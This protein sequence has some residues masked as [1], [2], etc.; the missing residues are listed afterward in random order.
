MQYRWD[1]DSDSTWDTGWSAESLAYN[2][3]PDDWNGL[4]TVVVTDGTDPTADTVEVEV[5]N[6]PPVVTVYTSDQQADTDQAVSFSGSFTDYGVLD[7]HV[8][9]WDFGDGASSTG[10]LSAIHSYSSSGT[11]T[12]SLTVTDDDGGTDTETVNIVVT[13]GGQAG[14]GGGIVIID[15]EEEEEED[16]ET[17]LPTGPILGNLETTKDRVLLDETFTISVVVTN[18]SNSTATYVIE[19]EL[20]GTV[21][22]TKE[23]TLGGSKSQT[24]SFQVTAETVGT[25]FVKI[26]ELTL[27]VEVLAPEEEVLPAD[28]AISNLSVTPAEI[29][30]GETVVISAVITN[31]GGTGIICK[32]RRVTISNNR[33]I[34]NGNN[35]LHI[36]DSTGDLE[37][38]K[39][40]LYSNSGRGIYLQN[41]IR[42][43]ITYN[44]IT[45]NSG[46]GFEIDS[47][48]EYNQIDHNTFINNNLGGVQ[49]D[50]SGIGNHWNDSV[51]EGNYWSD[52]ESRYVPGATNDGHIWDT[53]YDMTGGVGARDYYPFAYLQ[54]FEPRVLIDLSQSSGTTGDIFEFKCWA[55]QYVSI[56]DVWVQ[57]WFTDNIT[58]KTNI[59]MARV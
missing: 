32:G 36:S 17:P 30:P 50:D 56:K 8:I 47:N 21:V 4:T 37:I 5:E 48:S 15:D 11:Y 51:S 27:F 16:G 26:G 45:D 25:Y 57:F 49:G 44:L 13:G 54:T 23:V 52:Y 6:T 7:T 19:L 58:N 42:N 10:T 9:S 41:S 40:I 14:G 55:T 28:F 1:F 35:G 39:N 12:A 20:N 3:W 46:N 2:T 43:S 38:N 22:Q 34:D 31:N 53:P 18:S 24:V 29:K 33:V 59:T